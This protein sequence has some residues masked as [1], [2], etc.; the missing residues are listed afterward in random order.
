VSIGDPD[1]MKSDA[2]K[3]KQQGFPAIKVKL[4]ETKEKDV[5]RI[6]AI[7]DDTRPDLP[8]RIDANQGWK[9]ADY[10][11]EVLQALGEFNI[12]HCEEPILRHRFM[13][14]G[15][16]S[17]ASPIP[18]MADESCGDDHDAERLIQLKACRMFNIK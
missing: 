11:I 18:I 16:V 17:A 8:L 6:Q 3:F 9:T 7:R 4:G 12:E 15:K 14:L 10:A 1:K 5:A 13:E 2:A